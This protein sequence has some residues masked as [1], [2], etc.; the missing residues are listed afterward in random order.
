M[1]I[2]NKKG[3]SLRLI[4]VIKSLWL[5]LSTVCARVFDANT[6]LPKCR[7][8]SLELAVNRIEFQCRTYSAYSAVLYYCHKTNK[9]VWIKHI[10]TKRKVWMFIQAIS[11]DPIFC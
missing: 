5:V 4:N 9:F 3:I 10:D 11:H 1:E 6:V 7:V 8:I 2:L